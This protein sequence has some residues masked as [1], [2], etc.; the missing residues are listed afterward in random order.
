MSRAGLF[1]QCDCFRICYIL[2]NQK[3]F[4]KHISQLFLN[5]IVFIIDK[6]A[7]RAAAGRSLET[8]IKVKKYQVC[9]KAALNFK[10]FV[11]EIFGIYLVYF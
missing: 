7:A 11:T 4:R 6:M 2:P 3:I 10:F 1:T 5:I 9:K 8:L